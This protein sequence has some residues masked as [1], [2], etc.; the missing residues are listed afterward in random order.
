MVVAMDKTTELV[1]QRLNILAS[2][3]IL[4]EAVKGIAISA[5]DIIK[6]QAQEID[7]LRSQCN[8]LYAEI[9]R[10]EEK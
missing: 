3:T 6:K 4:T 7:D 8:L 5:A 10:K 1:V 2:N 9:A